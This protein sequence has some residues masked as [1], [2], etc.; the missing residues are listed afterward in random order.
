MR[1][2][3]KVLVQDYEWIHLSLGLTGNVLFFSG[4]VLFL[5]RLTGV[6]RPDWLAMEWQT[7][8]VWFFVVGSFLML[9]GALGRLLVSIWSE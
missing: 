8:G 3:I 1:N 5:P 2:P 9:V 4:S 7:L 6:Q